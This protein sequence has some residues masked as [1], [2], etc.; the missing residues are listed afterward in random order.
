MFYDRKPN[1][2]R[3]GR[4]RIKRRLKTR[5]PYTYSNEIDGR[6]EDDDDGSIAMPNGTGTAKSAVHTKSDSA[7]KTAKRI[8]VAPAWSKQALALAKWA[9]KRLVNRTDAWG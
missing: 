7:G 6:P 9:M 2:K 5:A 3:Q 4:G 1:A 8:Q